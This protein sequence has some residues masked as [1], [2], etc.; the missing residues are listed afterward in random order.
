MNKLIKEAFGELSLWGKF[1]LFLGLASLAAAAGMSFM[2]GWKMTVL[3][4][5]FLACLSFVTAFLPESAYRA[6]NEGRRGVAL[7]LALLSLPLFAVEFGQHAAYTAGIR[8]YD[9]A[10]TRV[11]NTRYDG[12]QDN[13]KENKALLVMFTRRL[14]EFES[15]NGWAAS[16]TA[17][18]LRASLD[19]AQ[20]A[21][22]LET[23]RGGCKAKCLDLMKSK[24]SLEERI[25]KV[26]ERSD[27][28]AKI[29]ATKTVL[30]NVRDKAAAVEHKSSQTE[31]MNAFLSKAV[32]F[33]G[34][35]ALKPNEY[36][37]E[38]TQLSA[39]LAMA[40]AG[41]GLPALAL[42]VAGLYRKREDESEAAPKAQTITATFPLLQARPQLAVG[43]PIF[44][45]VA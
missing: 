24:A 23:A 7:G 40:L 41:T 37:E 13:V 18:A 36:T 14:A 15:Q 16:T 20:K 31:H 4:A 17:V 39:N 1:W 5:L 44:Q 32:A 8:G 9:L 6:W 45:S 34:Q 19:S 22:D 12:A 33:V 27:L 2:V 10:E 43:R 38:G 42:F 25:A 28:T 26:E 30:A 29:E 21:I 11:Q 35:G 3:H